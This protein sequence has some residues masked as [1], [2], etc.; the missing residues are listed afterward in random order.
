MASFQNTWGKNYGKYFNREHLLKSLFFRILICGLAI[1][2]KVACYV[3]LCFLARLFLGGLSSKYLLG[4]ALLNF[5][6]LTGSCLPGLIQVKALFW[7]HFLSASSAQIMIFISI[8]GIFSSAPPLLWNARKA[9]SKFNERKQA[10]YC[11]RPLPT[12][13]LLFA[14]LTS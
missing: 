6:D 13:I 7:M 4:L 1:F 12:V 10:P 11:Q 2:K 3:C 5:Q 8:K 9:P 14:V